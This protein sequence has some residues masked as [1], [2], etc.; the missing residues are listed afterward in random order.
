MA[1]TIKEDESVADIEARR[2]AEQE[3][4][5]AAA[6]EAEARQREEEERKAAAKR[7]AEG[8]RIAELEAK[9]EKER[10][11]YEKRL[12]QFETALTGAFANKQ[13]AQPKPKPLTDEDFDTNPA[14][15]YRRLAREETGQMIQAVGQVYSKVLGGLAE[16]DFDRSLEALDNKRFGKLARKA[17]LDHFREHPEDK[18][19][20]GSV[21]EV[22]QR[23]VGKNID[24]YLELEQAEKAETPGGG[25]IPSGPKKPR[26]SVAEGRETSVSSRPA[27]PSHDKD[28]GPKL[29]GAEQA[30]FEKYR[31]F[32]IG[33]DTPEDWAAWRDE[34]YAQDREEI[35]DLTEA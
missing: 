7:E 1:V 15:A 16:R 25:E 14:E 31:K 30:M 19:N 13:D 28:E 8:S 6:K 32:G 27:L 10:E 2:K 11:D 9:R 33:I 18:L 12:A 17:V 35:P 3:K 29:S 34:L 20:A 26:I 23:V 22:Y 24:E 21:D 4:A 5:E